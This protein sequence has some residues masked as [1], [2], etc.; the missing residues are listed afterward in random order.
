MLACRLVG[1]RFRFSADGSTMRWSCTRG[2]GAGGEKTYAS[3]ADA[4][5]Y[6]RAFD[7]EDREDIG[8]RAPLIGLLPLRIVWLVRRRRRRAALDR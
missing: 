2:C 8:R 5:R 7:R 1:H 6:A 3:A 4:A